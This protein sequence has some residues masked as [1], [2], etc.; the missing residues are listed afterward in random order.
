VYWSQQ[1]EKIAPRPAQYWEIRLHLL[2][3]LIARARKTNDP[4]ERA[5]SLKQA[6]QQMLVLNKTSTTLGGPAFKPQF[7]AIQREL[8]REL[9]RKLDA[10]QTKATPRQTAK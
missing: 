4:H 6:E 2:G 8:E 5:Q 10:A 1:L 7:Q 9:G 3:A